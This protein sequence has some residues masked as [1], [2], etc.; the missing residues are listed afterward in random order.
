MVE[1]IAIAQACLRTLLDVPV[2]LNGLNDLNCLNGLF[3]FIDAYTRINS[4]KTLA[5]FA[6][7]IADAYIPTCRR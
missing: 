1:P 7:W 2:G 3:V 4:A 6:A 5:P